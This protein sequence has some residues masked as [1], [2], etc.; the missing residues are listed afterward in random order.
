MRQRRAGGAPSPRANR[1]P[2]T[3][4]ICGRGRRQRATAGVPGLVP[5]GLPAPRSRSPRRARKL[6]RHSRSTGR[7]R[8]CRARPADTVPGRGGPEASA[9]RRDRN[10]EPAHTLLTR[11]SDTGRNS[12]GPLHRPAG[13]VPAACRG[14]GQARSRHAA[15]GIGGL[16]GWMSWGQSLV[17]LGLWSQ[18]QRSATSFISRGRLHPWDGPI[19]T[20][21]MRPG[22]T[23]S[24]QRRDHSSPGPSLFI[25]LG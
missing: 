7:H 2:A 6:P 22:G 24:P 1:P 18:P 19:S 23:W 9:T 12:V 25:L 20:R 5:G 16:G 15:P 13:R 3:L 8:R 11:P 4:R 21:G 10:P 17:T 14:H